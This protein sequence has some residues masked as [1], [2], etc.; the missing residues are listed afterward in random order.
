L[1]APL[2]HHEGV[3]HRN[4][5]YFIDALGF[6]F[7]IKF[8]I[9]GQMGGRTGGGEGSGKG[10]HNNP[11]VAKNFL[12]GT[13]LPTKWVGPRNGFVTNTGLE[14]DIGNLSDYGHNFLAAL[15]ERFTTYRGF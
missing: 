6:D 9:A 8:F 15:F 10:K 5:N 14:H 4:A 12:G 3:I 13:V 1:L 2:E 7:F 11:L